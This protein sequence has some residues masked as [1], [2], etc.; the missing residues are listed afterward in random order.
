MTNN[1]QATDILHFDR[2]FFTDSK[3]HSRRFALV[4]L[5]SAVMN[6]TN[7]L[8]CSVITSKK[9]KYYALKLE[10]DKYECFT[11]DSYVCFRRRDIEALDDL[12]NKYQPVGKLSKL[13]IKEAFKIIK[14]VFYGAGDTLLMAT[15]IREWKQ[16]K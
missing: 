8:L 4:L 11:C 9:E 10:K 13:D 3:K 6:Y 2:Y 7:N 14:K 15:V 1:F 5:P 16:I 12:S